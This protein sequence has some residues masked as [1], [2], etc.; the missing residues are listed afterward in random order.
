MKLLR[1]SISKILTIAIAFLL[2]LYVIKASNEDSDFVLINDLNDS[3]FE[4]QVSNGTKN[5]WIII[6]YVDSCPHCKNSKQTLNNI[7]NNPDSISK[8]KIRLGK[9]DCDSNMFTCFRFKISRVPYIIIIDS[10]YMYELNEYP[11]NENIIKF[12]NLK[13]DTEEGLEIPRAVG[14][15]EFFYKSLE[16]LV[17]M[18][19]NTIEGYLKNSLGVKIDWRSEYTVGLLASLL[20]LII[21]VEYTILCIVCKVHGSK[22]KKA[23][24]DDNDN[25]EIKEE[26][27]E[28][29]KEDN[30]KNEA[31][32]TN[33]D[34]KDD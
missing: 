12:I 31:E 9:V 27:S 34:K 5:P 32:K 21:H 14:Y 4:S 16:E 15:L 17:H 33:T 25:K 26:I 3:N 20:V 23:V 1:I 18:M 7:A 2:S 30:G 11:S 13:K 28:K 29:N 22:E 19:D 8:S 6:F 10:N 24:V